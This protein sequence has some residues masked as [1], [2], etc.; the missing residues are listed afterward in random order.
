MTHIPKK[1]SLSDPSPDLTLVHRGKV[2]DTYAVSRSDLRLVVASNRVS[3]F[4]FVLP[5]EVPQKGAVLTAMNSFWRRQVLRDLCPHDL[6]DRSGEAVPAPFQ[7]ALGGNPELQARTTVVR[8]LDM[9]P[10][11]AIVRGALTGSELAAYRRDGAVC[12]HRLPTGLQDGD[13]LPFPIFTPSTKAEVGH[14]EH[15]TADSVVEQFGFKLERLVLQIFQTASAFAREHG[16]MIADTKFE[17]GV[18]N[19]ELVL[20]DE[21]LTPDSSRFW[22]AKEWRASR[23]AMTRQSPSSYDKQFVR[24]WGRELGIDKRNPANAEDLARVDALEVPADLLERTREIY[25]FIFWCLTGQKL[26]VFQR[27][28]MGIDVLPPTVRIEVVTGSESDLNQ[29]ADGL[30]YLDRLACQGMAHVRRH[31]ISCHRNPDELADYAKNVPRDVVIIAGAGLASALPGVLQ[32]LLANQGKGNIPVIGVAFAGKTESQNLAALLSIKEL[33][34][35]RVILDQDGKPYFGPEGFMAACRSAYEDEF[36][37]P[38]R[39]T[40]KPAKLDEPL[41]PPYMLR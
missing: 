24:A 15:I 6:A 34:D 16:I 13:A 28:D 12:G 31:V 10:C 33:P 19:N 5:A 11:E 25:R 23:G 22:N 41:L 27:A 2:R 4:D 37:M 18:R 38:T 20:A 21:V 36:L 9:L 3:I 39:P 30:A 26:E 40:P 14:D 32:A 29:M 35:Q 7:E 1:V 17:F 8:H